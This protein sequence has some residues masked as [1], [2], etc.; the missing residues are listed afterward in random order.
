[1][2]DC[3]RSTPESRGSLGFGKKGGLEEL[4]SEEDQTAQVET[5]DDMD[6]ARAPKYF[7]VKSA[8]LD[9]VESLPADSML[10][11][12]RTLSVRFCTSRTTVRQAL[13]ELVI[14]GRLRREQGR[15]TFVNSRKLAQPLLIGS[16]TN[17]MRR[18]GL[19]PQSRFL[20]VRYLAAPEEIASQLEVREG[21]RLVHIERLRLAS[22]DP[23]AIESTYLAAGRFPGLRKALMAHASL[24]EALQQR[25]GVELSQA[26]QTIETVLA[27]PRHAALLSTDVGAP[28]LLLS[29]VSRDR[30]AVPVEYV[31]S[32][33]RGDRYK[34]VVHI[35]RDPS[36]LDGYAAR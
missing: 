28:L 9:L 18:A 17:Y 16:F 1:M 2:S 11:P 15:G 31:R 21:V 27:T 20:E 36:S 23:M 26:Q 29:Q 24:Y 7:L 4:P 25:Y 10:P 22:G 6:G 34:F 14:E 12:E 19:E 33:Y 32:L 3:H 35:G 30:D 5:L 13:Q 8:L